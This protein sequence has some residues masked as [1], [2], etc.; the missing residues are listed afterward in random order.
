MVDTEKLKYTVVVNYDE[1]ARGIFDTFEEAEA[2]KVSLI[3]EKYPEDIKPNMS[4][5]DILQI[6]SD[7][8]FMILHVLLE[9]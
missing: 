3:K 9:D 8:Y 1:F 4:D 5:E 6:D 7:G 2:F